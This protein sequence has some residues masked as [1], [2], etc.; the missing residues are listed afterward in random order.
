MLKRNLAGWIFIAPAMSAIAV[1]FAL[2][3]LAALA[4]SLTDFDIYALADLATCA[5]SA[6]TTTRNCCRPR[7]SGRR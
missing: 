2:P 3:V 5:S 6:W 1:F 4:M 7:C